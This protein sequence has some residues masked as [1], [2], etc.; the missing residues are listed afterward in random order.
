MVQYS[1]STKCK[2]E[3]LDM[4]QE[5]N[6]MYLQ[7]KCFHT[8]IYHR[9]CTDSCKKNQVSYLCLVN[10]LELIFIYCLLPFPACIILER[11]L[12]SLGIEIR[13]T[14]FKGML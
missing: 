11:Y 14:I 7:L 4:R 9:M 3:L 8:Y 13:F 1:W 12:S 6:T 10:K 5:N 2:G